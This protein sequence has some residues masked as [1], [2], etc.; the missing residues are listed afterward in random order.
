MKAMKSK[1]QTEEESP[2]M[3]FE[4]MM[5]LNEIVQQLTSSCVVVV[6]SMS[7]WCIPIVVKNLCFS[8]G[9]KVV[10]LDKHV[11]RPDIQD[12]L[13]NKL[14]PPHKEVGVLWL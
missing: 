14:V 10:E 12:F 1:T 13:H 4:P 3:P 6:F 11:D 7:D 5:S 8:I 9:P 2:S